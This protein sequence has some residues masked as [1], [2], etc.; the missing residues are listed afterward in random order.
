VFALKLWLSSFGTSG[1]PGCSYIRSPG[2]YLVRHYHENRAWSRKMELSF[3]Q[4]NPA[5]P[6]VARLSLFLAVILNCCNLLTRLWPSLYFFSWNARTNWC[7]CATLS[8][9][10]W[11]VGRNLPPALVERILLPSTRAHGFGPRKGWWKGGV[12]V[13]KLP[14]S[15]YSGRTRWE[16]HL[17]VVEAVTDEHHAIHKRVHCERGGAS[18]STAISPYVRPCGSGVVETPLVTPSRYKSSCPT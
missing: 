5:T 14:A 1:R 2:S 18:V 17:D 15:P 16:G 8:S 11:N 9:F 7:K 13:G 12:V 4:V 10:I 6:R 3:R